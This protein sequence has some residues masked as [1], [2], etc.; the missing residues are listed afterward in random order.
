MF[1]TVCED[2]KKN[3]ALQT[4]DNSYWFRFSF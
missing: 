3:L 2:V 1:M 4:A